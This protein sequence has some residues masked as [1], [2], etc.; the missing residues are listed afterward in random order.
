VPPISVN[1]VP[2]P[3]LLPMP[4]DAEPVEPVLE[5]VLPVLEPAAPALPV[6]EPVDPVLEPALPAVDPVALVLGADEPIDPLPAPERLALISMKEPPLALELGELPVVPVAPVVPVVDALLPVVDALLPAPEPDTR[7]PVAT[8][9]CPELLLP[10]PV[11]PA[12]DPL[13]VCAAAP[14]PS[15]TAIIVP[16][17]NCRFITSS[18]LVEIRCLCTRHGYASLIANAGPLRLKRRRAP[19]FNPVSVELASG[20]CGCVWRDYNSR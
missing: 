18:V 15:A 4:L 9:G 8:T 12:C 1:V 19:I 14:A 20:H 13:G 3:L 10:L 16:K 2:A 11:L 5:P 6:L 7:H 17:R